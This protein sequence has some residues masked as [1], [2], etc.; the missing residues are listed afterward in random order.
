MTGQATDRVALTESGLIHVAEVGHGYGVRVHPDG[1][2]M[3]AD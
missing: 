2:R 3:W 1:C